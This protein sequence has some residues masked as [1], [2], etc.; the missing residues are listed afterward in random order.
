M[1]HICLFD[2]YT[3]YHCEMLLEILD[4]ILKTDRI[5]GIYIKTIENSV[6]IDNLIYVSIAGQS[7][8]NP[9][10]ERQKIKTVKEGLMIYGMSDRLKS[11][12][13]EK[14]YT[15]KLVAERVRTSQAEIC[16]YESGEKSPGLERLLQLSIV[17]RCSLDY[18]VGKDTR[19]SHWG[20]D[21]DA[22]IGT[23]CKKK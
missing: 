18:L 6:K 9:G 8:S 13:M 21:E 7:C 16:R 12:R 17:Y 3:L 19:R 14:G 4:I 11:L 22:H 23:C 20:D 10:K 1:T 15:Q 2:D 5:I